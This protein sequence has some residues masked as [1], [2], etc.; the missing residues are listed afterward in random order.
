MVM[1]GERR[2]AKRLGRKGD[3]KGD[4]KGDWGGGTEEGFNLWV[5][6]TIEKM[7]R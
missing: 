6:F 3:G 5:G 1:G 7:P 2:G 4:G